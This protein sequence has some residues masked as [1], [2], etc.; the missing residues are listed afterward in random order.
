MKQDGVAGYSPASV[1]ISATEGGGLRELPRRFDGRQQELERLGY[2]FIIG[3][4]LEQGTQLCEFYK[5]LTEGGGEGNE[6]VSGKPL[7][8]T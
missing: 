7:A 6:A 2:K 8:R 1:D 3:C 5:M 4:D